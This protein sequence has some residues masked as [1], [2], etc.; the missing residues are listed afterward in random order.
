MN[1]FGMLAGPILIGLF[2]VFLSA[3]WFYPKAEDGHYRLEQW[4]PLKT[5]ALKQLFRRIGWTCLVV[6]FGLVSW[7]MVIFD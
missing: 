2:P 3:S 4:I 7:N 1:R 6:G 5:Q